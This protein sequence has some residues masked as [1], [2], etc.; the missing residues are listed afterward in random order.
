MSLN[1]INNNNNTLQKL[2][3]QLLSYPLTLLPVNNFAYAMF[4]NINLILFS[5]LNL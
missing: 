5:S 4:K 3:N 2:C 1:I